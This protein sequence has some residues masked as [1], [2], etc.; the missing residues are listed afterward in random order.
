MDI[1][2]ESPKVVIRFTVNGEFSDALNLSQE[3]FAALK[4]G[5]LEELQTV[6]YNSWKQSISQVS[7]IVGPEP[8]VEELQ[9]Q[10]EAVAVEQAGLEQ[11]LQSVL[12]KTKGLA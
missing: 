8:T 11:Q 12:A 1:T 4:P 7:K 6:R 5:E 3:E 2:V 9:A 10:L